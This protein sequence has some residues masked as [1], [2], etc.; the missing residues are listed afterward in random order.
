MSLFARRRPIGPTARELAEGLAW[1]IE[2]L[3]A[4][5][6]P[7]GAREGA[8]WRAGGLAGDAGRSLSV[9]LAGKNAGLWQ[10]RASGDAGDALDLVREV[11]GL[12][13]RDACKWA[14]GW[15]GLDTPLAVARPSRPCPTVAIL[16][17]DTERRARAM[18]RWDEAIPLAGTQAEAYLAAR[19]L[20]LERPIASLRFAPAATWHPRTR[21][22][23]PALVALV[24]GPDGPSAI[25]ATYLDP[26]GGPRKAP[27]LD[28]LKVCYGPVSGGAV[29]LAEPTDGRLVLAEGLE[30]ALTVMLAWKLPAWATLGTSG[31]KGVIVPATVKDVVIAADRDEPGEAAAKA[32]AQRL[33]LEGRRVRIARPSEPHKDF[34]AMLQAGGEVLRG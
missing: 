1:R 10:D 32:L 13:N 28:P 21:D 17:D 26:A 25:Q 9:Q 18:R 29:H 19:G 6:L 11:L 22:T 8:T 30:D 7:E 12:D 2:A 16:P 3:V 15:L 4:D 23:M 34:N 33:V 5:L 31:L 20:V 14:A 24:D 27:G